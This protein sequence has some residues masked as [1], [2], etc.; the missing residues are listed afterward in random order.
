VQTATE[1]ELLTRCEAGDV[2]VKKGGRPVLVEEFRSGER[3]MI[4]LWWVAHRGWMPGPHPG[5]ERFSRSAEGLR[6]RG[7]VAPQ[8]LERGMVPGSPVRWVTYARIAGD[9]LTQLS[10]SRRFALLPRM[11]TWLQRLHDAGCYC[12]SLSLANVLASPDHD[13]ALVDVSDTRFSLRPLSYRRRVRNLGRFLAHPRD[14]AWWFESAGQRL[15]TDYAR[16]C[17]FDP[18]DLWRDVERNVR[19]RTRRLHLRRRR[20]SDRD[21]D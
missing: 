13:L 12:R 2:I 21:A 7:I 5:F 3:I 6:A 15:V 17:V 11:S 19:S 20:R 14:T 16:A 10:D 1:H 8:V 9:P 4:K 18:T